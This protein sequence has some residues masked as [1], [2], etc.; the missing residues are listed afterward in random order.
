MIRAVFAAVVLLCVASVPAWCTNYPAVDYQKLEHFEIRYTWTGDGGGVIDAYVDLTCRA[1]RPAGT[2][3][4]INIHYELMVYANCTTE[5]PPNPPNMG[6]QLYQGSCQVTGSLPI[7]FMQ[8]LD[9]RNGYGAVLNKVSTPGTYSGA[10]QLTMYSA[11]KSVNYTFDL[12]EDGL[13]TGGDNGEPPPVP[14]T[15]PGNPIYTAPDPNEH[16]WW[17]NFWASQ[18]ELSPETKAAWEGMINN[19]KT[20]GPWGQAAALS[21]QSSSALLRQSFP[22]GFMLPRWAADGTPLQPL[23]VYGIQKD[24]LISTDRFLPT[25]GTW[26]LTNP[27]FTT[28]AGPKSVNFYMGGLRKLLRGVLW[29]GFAISTVYWIRGKITA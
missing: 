24:T 8:G 3:P 29:I 13:A 25:D 11:V 12:S 28:E 16:T 22:D 17:E 15:T 14:G 23:M 18:T 20:M 21:N 5:N 27:W 26:T 9:F 4:L 7:G 6:A 10:I 19:L 1:T 2:S